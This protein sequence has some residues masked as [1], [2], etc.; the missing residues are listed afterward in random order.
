MAKR[1]PPLEH[2]GSLITYRDGDG[3]R[4]LGYL[5]HSAEHGTYD[6][7]LGRVDVTREEADVHNRLLSE[8]LIKGLDERC[9]VGM[10]G[11][12]YLRTGSSAQVRTWTGDVVSS[13]VAIRGDA[14]TFCRKGMT[15]RG[16]LPKDGQAFHFR[17]VS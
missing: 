6:A 4:C 3:E 10:G 9:A 11:T 13:D 1:T 2:K 5:F 7:A 15:F 12:F 16:R 14:I 17:R 8:A